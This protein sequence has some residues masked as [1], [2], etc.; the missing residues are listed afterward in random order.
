[1]NESFQLRTE[2]LG[3]LPIINHFIGRLGL[4]G[5]IE[6]FVP[7][8]DRRVVLPYARGLG[9][10]L[11]SIL[12]EREP[13]YRQQETVCTFSP[14]A[15]DL[16]PGEVDLISD[17]RIRR[18]LDRLFEADRGALLT[19]VM[20]SAA[21]R[22]SLSYKDFHNVTSTVSFA[23]Q[24]RNARGRSL[25]GH[26]APWITFGHPKNHRPDLKQLMIVLTTTHD[27]GVPVQFRCED[28]N[29]SDSHTHIHTWTFLRELCGYSDFL[30]V[31]D[32]K[33]CTR[34][35]MDHID[36]QGGRFVTVIP[37]SRLE[38][39][40]FR[41]WIQT[42]EPAWEKVWDRPNPHR[43]HG[44]RDRWYVHRYHIPS[45]EGW[46][47]TWV[48][49]SLLALRQEETRREQLATAMQKLQ[50]LKERL[51]NPGTRLK[52]KEEVCELIDTLLA[53]QQVTRY[54]KVV[55][56]TK[57]TDEFKQETRGRPGPNTRYHRVTKRRLTIEWTLDTAAIEYDRKSDGMYPLLTNDKTLLS[58][59][60]LKAHKRQ[61]TIEKRFSQLKSVYEIAPVFLKNEGR[62]EALF[63]LYF[64]AMLIQGLIERELR[65]AMKREE[66]FSLPL[67]GE[68]R[69]CH[70]PTCEQVFRLFSLPARHVLYKDGQE[71][72]VFNQELTELQ[73]KVLT[74]LGVPMNVYCR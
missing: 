38:D 23:G 40:E 63:F 7:T 73:H 70:Y 44:P 62:I 1:M 54:L 36:H 14:A 3:P 34:E 21:T 9:I 19:E 27:G 30:Y 71:I 51:A 65:N 50:D 5:L 15:F 37:R 69:Q 22:F 41:K 32:C 25:R 61:P 12:V 31:A 28:G 53:H 42:H 45:R 18:A 6:R 47:V 67:Y 59:E 72:M 33:L 29:A 20:V 68:A 48:L 60:I 8:D 17:D 35:N 16:A 55:I 2:R 52:R 11:R 49:S 66:I 58:S 43:T 24:Y 74:L 39:R 57:K 26:R 64:F 4:T 46:P 56:R 13:I 10:L